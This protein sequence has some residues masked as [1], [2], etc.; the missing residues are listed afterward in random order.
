KTKETPAVAN[1]TINVLSPGRRL[2]R[3]GSYVA[4]ESRAEDPTANNTTNATFLA[5]FVSKVSDGSFKIVGKRPPACD[6]C[7][8]DVIHFPT[9][10]DYDPALAPHALV[11]ASALNFKP[12]GTLVEKTD[13]AGLN[14]TPSG[15]I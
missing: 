2:S 11:F 8:G 5:V 7:I 15:L 9:F 4:Y 6:T 13:A 14:A 10:T 1:A 12:D 3:D